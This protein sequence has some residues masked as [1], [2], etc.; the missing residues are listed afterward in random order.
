[1]DSG[2]IKDISSYWRAGVALFVVL[3]F[4]FFILFQFVGMNG[5]V[6][7]GVEI[8]VD[9]STTGKGYKVDVT[10]DSVE[11]PGSL[12]VTGAANG[13]LFEVLDQGDR[14]ESA[15]ICSG[16]SSG[17]RFV[18]SSPLRKGDKLKFVQQIDGK[19]ATVRTYEIHSLKDTD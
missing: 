19:N 9:Q 7:P 13:T 10:I 1:M 6:A 18:D 15:Y 17:R 16:C 3:V 4:V 5:G 8:T 2:G 14:G 12:Y 11:K